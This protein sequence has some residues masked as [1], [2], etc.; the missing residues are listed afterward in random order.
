M[1]NVA[2][3]KVSRRWRHHG[4]F[5]PNGS[6]GPSI[7]RRFVCN[8]AI[9]G[10]AEVVCRGLSFMAMLSLASRLKPSGLGRI[11][12][13]FNVVFWLVLIV[14]DCFETIIT[15]EIARHPR[16]TKK[17][18]NHVL[19]VKLALATGLLT[20]LVLVSFAAYS[21]PIDQWV[22]SLYGL[23]LLTA[24]L[25]LD[26][27]FRGN[28]AMGLV[29]V[30]L[31]LRTLIYCG[32]VWIWVVDPSKILFVPIG[33]AVGELTGISLVWVVYTRRFGIPRPTFGR[34]FLRVIVRKGRSV[35]LIHFC[36]TVII[37]AD[38]LVVG[39]MSSWSDVGCYS[40]PLRLFSA[41]MA[42]GTIFQQVI[43]P[44]LSRS[45]R[46]SPG[47]TREILDF[48]IKVMVTAFLPIAVGG[49]VL[50]V[51]LIGLMPANFERSAGLLAVGI[52]RA[53]LLSLAFLYQAAL[54]AT[55]RESHGVRLLMWGAIA[56]L[57]LIAGF[58]LLLGVSGASL[59]VI[60]NGLGL[61]V[62]GYV[63][64]SRGGCRPAGHHHL[65]RPLLASTLMVPV[66]LVGASAHVGV[67][68]LG[69]AGAYLLALHLLGGWDFGSKI[70][71]AYSREGSQMRVDGA[72]QDRAGGF[73]G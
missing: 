33:L 12:F 54:I 48:A 24:A 66:C 52:W 53:P 16:L 29:A 1:T 27:V 60:V 63:C 50:A 4:S 72:S 57:P 5:P 51:P 6:R 26:F 8:F 44:S 46:G 59:G 30:S 49:T 23:L 67:G 40:L 41:L 65:A 56:S 35:G 15:R 38:L 71:F 2:G 19:A 64:L 7:I 39:L 28:E 11:E 69:G 58:W 70:L 9:L 17:L 3:T 31:C 20:L 61:L 47:L 18:V 25:G 45:W 13:S 10:V 42:M 36:Q 68:V 21:D 73:E 55:N 43:F 62:A 37:S 32:C 34:R 22:M 14:R